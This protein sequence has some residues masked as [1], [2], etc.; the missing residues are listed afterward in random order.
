M[1]KFIAFVL[2]VCLSAMCVFSL[3]ACGGTSGTG[4]AGA[5]L[6][7]V[8][9]KNRNLHIAGSDNNITDFEAP[10]AGYIYQ[11]GKDKAEIV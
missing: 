1:K 8:S 7:L 9:G 4:V 5:V 11:V 3:T 10:E 2:A 6:K